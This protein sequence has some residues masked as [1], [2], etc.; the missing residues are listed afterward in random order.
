MKHFG[1]SSL[2]IFAL[3]ILTFSLDC[4][5]QSV[6]DVARKERERHK[7]TK[8]TIVVT[9]SGTSATASPSTT[10]S[11]PAEPTAAST[12]SAAKPSELIDNKGRNETFWRAAFQRARDDVKRAEARAQLL[13]LKLKDLN[14]Q[15][16]RQSEVYNRENR[17]GLEITTTQKE[18]EDARKEVEQAKKKIGDLEEELRRS[19]GPAGWA[20]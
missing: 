8:S 15:L 14:T 4:F 6:A 12:T 7:S 19:G 9:G 17:I 1:L 2:G 3:L 13:D 16:L 11:T 5:A 20:R 10:R 18:L